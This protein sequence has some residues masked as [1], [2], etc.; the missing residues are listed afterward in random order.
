MT[1]KEFQRSLAEPT[2]PPGLEAP[3]RA[4]WFAAKGDWGQAHSI[5]QKDEADPAHAWVHAHLHREE[6]DLANAAYWYRR[7]GRPVGEGDI[8][9]ERA[10]ILEVLLSTPA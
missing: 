10:E 3:V 9:R 5:V 7:A 1:P 8:A 2:P 6:G 4:L